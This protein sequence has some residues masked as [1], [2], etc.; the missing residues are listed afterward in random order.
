MDRVVASKNSKGLGVDV[1][2]LLRNVDLD[3]YHA[4][5]YICGKRGFLECGRR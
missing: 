4:R 5:D 2:G 3:K 1:K